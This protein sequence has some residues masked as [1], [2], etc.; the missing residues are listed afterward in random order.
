MQISQALETHDMEKIRSLS[1]GI[2][3][4]AANLSA[5]PVS[6]AAERLE[7]VSTTGNVQKTWQAFEQLRTAAQELK[8]HLCPKESPPQ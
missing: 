8:L 4:G 5:L 6:Y 1:H 7:Q 3:G 2:K